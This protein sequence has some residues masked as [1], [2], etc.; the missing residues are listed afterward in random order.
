MDAR[1]AHSGLSIQTRFTVDL[2]LAAEIPG[3]PAPP[4]ANHAEVG[5][6]R[7]D[8]EAGHIC[9]EGAP[10]DRVLGIAQNRRIQIGGPAISVRK[11]PPFIDGPVCI[12]ATLYRRRKGGSL[13]V[14]TLA[15]RQ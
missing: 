5:N 2:G 12:E 9:L 10:S 7:K 6:C 4:S 1:S 15:N 11:P 8:C 14:D 13:R 3:L